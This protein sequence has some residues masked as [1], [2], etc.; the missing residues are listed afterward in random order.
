VISG[1]GIGYHINDYLSTIPFSRFRGRVQLLR[2][3]LPLRLGKM[4]RLWRNRARLSSGCPLQTKK[5]R[6]QMKKIK[7]WNSDT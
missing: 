1:L 5:L 4:I 3:Q 7:W 6:G 2:R